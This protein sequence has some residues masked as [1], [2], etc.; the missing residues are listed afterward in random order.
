MQMGTWGMDFAACSFVVFPIGS[1][2]NYDSSIAI[3]MPLRSLDMKFA[4]WIEFLYRE[5]ERVQ[6]RLLWSGWLARKLCRDALKLIEFVEVC[7][8]HTHFAARLTDYS[9]GCRVPV[10]AS[11]CPL[12]KSSKLRR[13]P[14]AERLMRREAKPR[15]GLHDWHFRD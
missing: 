1:N 5:R 14:S 15:E 8:F 4:C 3:W 9:N 6:F 2:V 12:L 13:V 11:T 10:A 7:H